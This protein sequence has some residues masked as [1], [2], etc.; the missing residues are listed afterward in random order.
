MP[1][2]VSITA[3]CSSRA[4]RASSARPTPF[5]GASATIPDGENGGITGIV[6]YAVTRAENDPELAAA[7]VWEPG[8][9][10]V[11][12]NL[13]ESLGVDPLTGVATKGAAQHHR[14][15]QLGRSIPTGCKYGDERRRTVHVLARR[16]H[17]LRA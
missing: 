13:Y 7:E 14:H 16:G 11:T 10:G 2:T 3:R 17:L 8:I 15:R 9:P 4:S 5:C 6:F 1:S 12:V